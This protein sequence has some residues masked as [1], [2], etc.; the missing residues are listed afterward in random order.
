MRSALLRFYCLVLFSCLGLAVSAQD[1]AFNHRLDS[2][3]AKDNIIAWVY[4]R[5]DYA[6]ARPKIRLSYLIETQKE[7]WRKTKKEEEDHAYLS[8]LNT[9]GYYQLLEGNIL[10]SIN[11]YEAAYAYYVKQ[12]ASNY[13]ITEY[14]LKP[15]SNNYTRLGDYE[16]ALKLQ[17]NTL[18]YLIKTKQAPEDIASLY[19]SISTS[20]RSMGKLE[21]AEKNVRTGLQLAKAGVGVDFILNNILANILI[22]KGDNAAA[23]KLAEND[24][25][26]QKDVNFDNAY[27]LMGAYSTAGLA[28]FNLKNAKKAD[29]YLHKALHIFNTY[30][31]GSR[32]REKANILILKGN[33]KLSQN[34][35][36]LAIELFNNALF[37]L[38]ITDK[39]NRIITKEIY[40]DNKLVDIF[41]QKANA[42]LQLKKPMDALANIKLALFYAD[43][44]RNEFADDVTKERLQANLKNLTE[45]GIEIGYLQY[46]QTKDKNL[47][48]EILDL[49]EYSKGR[50]L[51]DQ[52]NK[53]QL[54]ISNQTKDP[55]FKEKLALERAIIY[56]EKQKIEAKENKSNKTTAALKFDLVLVNK[57]IKQKYKQFN[58]EEH[59]IPISKLLST[60][61]N[62]RIIEYFVGRDL[63]YLID[64][65]NKKVNNVIK[66]E[67]AAQIRS[68]IQTYNTVYFQQGPNAMLNAPKEFYQASYNLYQS[69]LKGTKFTKGESVVIVPDGALG[70][71]SFDGLIT[72]GKYNPNIANW[73]FLIKQNTISY[74]FSLKTLTANKTASQN[75]NFTGLFITHQKNNNKP[76]KAVEDEAAAIKKI[77]KGDFLFNEEVNASTFNKAFEKS[78]VLHIGTHAY[79]SGK[80]QEP[81]LDFD[82]EKLF[83]FELAAKKQAPA[84]V[85][86]S[87]C[88]TADGL[89][90]NG[91]GV[92]SLS[93]G[94]N[95]IGTPATIAGL[96]NVNDVAASVITSNFYKHLLQQQSSGNAL[97]Q[98]KLDWLNAPQTAD[99]FYLPYYWDSLIY[100]GTDQQIELA[101]TTNWRLL[102][103]IGITLIAV[104]GL[105][106]WMK[107]RFF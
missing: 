79:L 89:L 61:P 68:A 1:V 9:Q 102:L 48:N 17:L 92:I 60:L 23:V 43:K 72:D 21:D 41:E 39:N 99:A 40:G 91:E 31:R 19:G 101:T 104:M 84:L 51:L 65:H 47:L 46:Q 7:L 69:I 13:E 87:A 94:F 62:Q 95:A 103:G 57:K 82:K 35:P 2:L 32:L 96:W 37:T 71:I 75:Q 38:K 105:V 56:N 106:V 45:R 25:A 53:N 100:M 88:R 80:N 27:L 50:T 85:L 33:I 30:F 55:L 77:V 44:I 107:R 34:Q 90:A 63:I 93:R 81:T 20:Y 78:S 64:I 26:K 52:I 58:I 15:L 76:L 22:E 29:V 36:L 66:I 73:P 4:E 8:L 6:I 86:L 67:N 59:S 24:I 97:H 16:R 5:L 11:C 49:A 28:H 83:L 10:E 18:N 70:Y 74:A 98:A 12:K 14:T 3:R 54:L 42:Y